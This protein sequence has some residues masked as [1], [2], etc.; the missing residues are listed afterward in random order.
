[1]LKRLLGAVLVTALCAL[2]AQA[3]DDD[4]DNPVV[5]RV[6]GS[7]ISA[8]DIAF[9]AAAL[10]Q[11]FAQVPAEERPQMVLD[12]LIDMKVLAQAAEET[13]LDADP[14]LAR[15]VDFYRTSTLRDLYME[16][17]IADKITEDAVRERYD[18]EAAQ[19]GPTKEVSARHILVADEDRAKELIVAL[20][21]GADFA[22]L[23][24]ENSTDPGSAARGGS[25]GFFGRGQMVP[26]FEA[27]AFALA[28]GEHTKDPVQSR[29]GYHVIKVDEVRD[30]PVPAFEEVKDR[31]ED[32]MRRE[33]FVAEVARLKQ[34]AKIERLA[35]PAQ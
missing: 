20:D 29:F 26:P 7:D 34:E 18:A 22:E 23:A 9:A 5:A 12:F 16:K 4:G 28:V 14:A 15:R 10:G 30:V 8:S 2:P 13:G 6:N 19:V 3:Q 31:I 35:P 24:G 33:A 11:T 32:L 25:L 27:A 21:G 1:M 17:L